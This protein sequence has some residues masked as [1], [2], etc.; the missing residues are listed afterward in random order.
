M[1]IRAKGLLSWAFFYFLLS[2]NSLAAELSDTFESPQ[3]WDLDQSTLIINKTLGRVHPSLSVVGW[4]HNAVN[5]NTSFNV[6]DG[7]HGAFVS[8]RY[9][10]FGTLS[11]GV[12]TINTDERQELAV[13][14]FILESGVTLRPEGSKPLIIRSQTSV[15]ISGVI[16]CSGSNGSD[17]GSGGLGRCGGANGGAG[18][19][20][21]GDRGATGSSA[22][23]GSTGG[24]GGLDGDGGGGGGAYS[25]TTAPD[26]AE[27]GV[28]A[29]GGTKGSSTEQPQFT[30]LLG[31]SGGGGGGVGATSSGGGGGAGGGVVAIYAAGN[32]RVPASGEIRANGGNGGNSSDGGDGGGGAGGSILIFSGGV[33]DFLGLGA[34]YRITALAGDEP[35]GV[36]NRGKGAAGRTWIVD[37]D[38]A[39]SEG[40]PNGGIDDPQAGFDTAIGKVAFATSE[41]ILLSKVI[42]LKSTAPTLNTL[43]MTTQ[44]NG[45]STASL[46]VRASHDGF[47]NHATS[48]V[49]NT[50]LDQVSGYRYLQLRIKL[51]NAESYNYSYIDELV[52]DFDYFR[53]DN[54]EMTSACGRLG[55]TPWASLVGILLLSALY[56]FLRKS[57][58]QIQT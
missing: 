17:S 29:T 13:T 54:F 40:F 2:T 21:P 50:Q 22:G 15:D 12:L 46:E 5:D 10:E 35:G 57:T 18:S 52:L 19:T 55:E 48:W 44:L 42:D 1:G 36:A 6:G 47:T 49:T 11:G 53:Q 43:S 33:I 26:S 37:A 8:S 7:R 20:Q 30:N 4:E 28:G 9:S 38:D 24:Q 41:E 34:P 58:T 3:L 32:I 39:G 31:G 56:I 25:R 16:D 51:T 23:A 27:D 45:A 14:V